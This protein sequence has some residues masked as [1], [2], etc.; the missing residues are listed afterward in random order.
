MN[1]SHHKI[2]NTGAFIFV[3]A[4]LLVMLLQNIAGPGYKASNTEMLANAGSTERWILPHQFRSIAENDQLQNYL[5]VDLRQ[6][7]EFNQGSLPGAVNI[8]LENLLERKSM[9]LLKVNK[10][11]LLFSGKEAQA[12]VAGL[13]LYGEGFSNVLVLAN[14]YGYIKNNVL[15]KFEPSTAFTHEE[16]ARYDYHRFFKAA[17]RPVSQPA[18]SQP[19]IMETKVISVEG[20]C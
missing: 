5:L 9:K 19:K 18:A 4:T 3:G 17:P 14:D 7:E 6:R 16:K 12:S 20:G 15:G 8:P 10:P 2:L 11:V 13:L 1:D